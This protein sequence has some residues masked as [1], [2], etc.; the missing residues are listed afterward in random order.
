MERKSV[1]PLVVLVFVLLVPVV[2]Y[3][4]GIEEDMP[5]DIEISGKYLPYMSYTWAFVIV[6]LSALGVFLVIVFIAGKSLHDTTKK[7][8]YSS[9]AVLISLITIYLVASTLYVN[10]ISETKGPVHWHADLE[11]WNCGER[12]GIIDPRGLSSKVGTNVLHE[13]NDNRIH[14]EGVVVERHHADLHNFFK[15]VGGYL[16]GGRLGVPT[17]GGFE[18]IS[19][20][21]LCD[22]KPGKLQ[23]FVYNVLNPES[24]GVWRFT[25]EK[26]LNFEDYILSPYSNVP[27][28]DC[29]IIEFDQEKDFTDRMCST[30]RQGVQKGDMI[31]S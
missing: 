12:I 23:A 18:E 7:L 26:L 20:G 22:G 4:H 15:T 3:S 30:Y 13:H 19:D 5:K 25:Q 6:G 21:S 1:L 9:I 24:A 14:V 28:G 29:I 31:G 10:L 16:G 2:A 27:P 11:I 8:L 17:N